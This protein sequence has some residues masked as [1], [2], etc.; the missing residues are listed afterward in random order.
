MTYV[1]KDTNDLVLGIM[2]ILIVCIPLVSLIGFIEANSQK[3]IHDN[4]IKGNSPCIFLK[5]F[6]SSS[7]KN[8][9]PLFYDGATRKA[10]SEECRD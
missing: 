4:W 3:L 8:S 10:N 2:L 6:V 5:D 7:D 9:W 1:Y